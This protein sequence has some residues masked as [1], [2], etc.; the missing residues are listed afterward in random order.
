MRTIFALVMVAEQ[1]V[2][3]LRTD[4]EGSLRRLAARIVASVWQD[5][6]LNR[7]VAFLVGDLDLAQ[8]AVLVVLAL[9]DQHRH[10]DIAE[11]ISDVPVAK[12]RIEP[13]L[14]PGAERAIDIGVPALE[15]VP[16][17]PGGERGACPLDLGDTYVLG[18]KMRRHQHQAAHP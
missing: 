4:T 1:P 17:L 12:F 10:P 16:Q 13:W 7:R 6:S 9:H 5:R 11:G 18:E 2:D 8:R 3:K 15:L 14:A